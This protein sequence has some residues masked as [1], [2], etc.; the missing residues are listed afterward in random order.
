[1][2][3]LIRPFRY[4]P[5]GPPF[6]AS[7]DEKVNYPK[8]LIPILDLDNYP[9]EHEILGT[10]WD[11]GTNLY[12]G[13]NTTVHFYYRNN[14][15]GDPLFEW[16]QVIPDPSDFGHTYWNTYWIVCWI[17][18]CSWEVDKAMTVACEIV[19]TSNTLGNSTETKYWSVSADNPI[20]PDPDPPEPP[21]EPP[22]PPEPGV[23]PDFLLDPIG[24]IQCT[25]LNSIIAFSD[26]I[27]GYI[28]DYI[29]PVYEWF[30]NVGTLI[31]DFLG[32]IKGGIEEAVGGVVATISDVTSAISTGIS[33]W[34]TNVYATLQLGW[35]NIVSGLE[36]WIDDTYS[37]ITD[38]WTTQKEILQ[39]GWDNTVSGLFNWIDETYTN[40]SSWWADQ[41]VILQTGWDNTVSGISSWLDNQIVI[42]QTGWTKVVGDMQGWWGDQVTIMQTG[43]DK[44][45]GDMQGWWQDQATIMQQGWDN[46]VS[47]IG[48]I[49][50]DLQK[51]IDDFEWPDVSAIVLGILN[52]N[53]I[54]KFFTD[55]MTKPLERDPRI[56]SNV[57]KRKEIQSEIKELIEELS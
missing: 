19:V 24:W 39:R 8:T 35:E 51:Q 1:M 38:W 18:K 45:V 53:P 17:G 54:F 44:V 28:T 26:W 27:V 15:T 7:T 47:Q 10:R 21:P 23:C 40:I 48:D 49:T 2:A 13:H 14:D 12:N 46:T 11:C 31:S 22:E 57:E 52:V 5:P 20:P 36:S 25:I 30:E 37:S 4:N 29:A 55:L 41:L 50:A 9:I 34:W 6:E 42:L 3:V 56:L 43:W 16:H 33:D 32:D